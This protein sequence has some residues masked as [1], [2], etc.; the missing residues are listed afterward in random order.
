[1][2]HPRRCLTVEVRSKFIISHLFAIGVYCGFIVDSLSVVL[3]TGFCGALSPRRAL[4]F[5]KFSLLLLFPPSELQGSPL[6]F[7]SPEGRQ[8]AVCSP[9]T[10]KR[11]LLSLFS[12]GFSSSS[13]T[14]SCCHCHSSSWHLS[15]CFHSFCFI[16]ADMCLLDSLELVLQAA[17]SHQVDAWNWTQVPWKSSSVLN[18]GANSSSP[19]S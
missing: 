19:T 17:V 8:P 15:W 6:L 13:L 14:H 9:F 11:S 3:G 16:N 12:S 2:R 7:W 4:F 18:H 10:C 5:L 1:M